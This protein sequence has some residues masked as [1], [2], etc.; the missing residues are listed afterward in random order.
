MHFNG[1][2]TSSTCFHE[3]LKHVD[4]V[5]KLLGFSKLRDFAR[6]VSIANRMGASKIKD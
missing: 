6:Y 5:S 4:D 1:F 2:I 3:I